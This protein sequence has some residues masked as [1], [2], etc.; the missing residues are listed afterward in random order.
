MSKTAINVFNETEITNTAYDNDV[1]EWMRSV[2]VQVEFKRDK[3]FTTLFIGDT[4]DSTMSGST[5]M[6]ID[7]IN[8]L[9]Y[10][11]DLSNSKAKEVKE[12]LTTILNK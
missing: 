9:F 3:Y 6:A 8:D 1:A 7:A 11:H 2:S 4:K 12:K 5:S 10:R